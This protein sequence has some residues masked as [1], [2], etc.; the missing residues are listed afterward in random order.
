MNTPAKYTKEQREELIQLW[1]DS[2]KGKKQF[3]DEHGIKYMTFID[4]VRK[5]QR[6]R[7]LKIP[8]EQFIPLEIP[9]SSIFAELTFGGKKIIFHQSVPA[10]YLKTILR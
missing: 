3:A 6:K 8:S 5:R 9:G 10:E 4:W 2:G 7:S 1:K